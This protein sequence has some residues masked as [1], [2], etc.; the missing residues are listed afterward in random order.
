MKRR[1]LLLGLSAAAL[2][3][4]LPRRALAELSCVQNRWC[5]VDIPDFRPPQPAD[6]RQRQCKEWSAAF[7]LQ[8]LFQ[9]HGHTIGDAQ[10]IYSRLYGTQSCANLLPPVKAIAGEWQDDAGK[11]FTVDVNVLL[12]VRAASPENITATMIAELTARRPLLITFGNTTASRYDLVH[13]TAMI[14]GASY[15]EDAGDKLALTS[16]MVRDLHYRH[17]RWRIATPYDVTNALMVAAVRVS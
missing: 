10:S 15:F 2:A 11:P 4:A 17:I 14:F 5:Q 1:S 3:P 7:S 8:A 9:F 6:R 16:A 13:A 12:P